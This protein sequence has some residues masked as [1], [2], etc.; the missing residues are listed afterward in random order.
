MTPFASIIGQYAVN[1][2]HI[3]DHIEDYADRLRTLA[4]MMH[5]ASMRLRIALCS[6]EDMKSVL[7]EGK[8]LEGDSGVGH[9]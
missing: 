3:S 9:G 5:S 1:T 8:A 7:E 2:A 4:D 6:R